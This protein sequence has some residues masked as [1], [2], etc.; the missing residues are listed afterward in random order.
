MAMDDNG[1]NAY[2]G[3]VIHEPKRVIR[4]YGAS[5]ISIIKYNGQ[6]HFQVQGGRSCIL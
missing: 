6:N 1:P 5:L 4:P 2:D 3:V